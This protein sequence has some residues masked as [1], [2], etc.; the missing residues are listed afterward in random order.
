MS[1]KILSV[2]WLRERILRALSCD[3]AHNE[4]IR[5]CGTVERTCAHVHILP[6]FCPIAGGVAQIIKS[7]EKTKMLMINGG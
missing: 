7:G 5:M 2:C 4:R 6:L 1:H 3:T